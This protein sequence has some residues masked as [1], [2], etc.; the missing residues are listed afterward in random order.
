MEKPEA[1]FH[2]VGKV[3][4]KD[5]KHHRHF[6]PAFTE[7]LSNGQGCFNVREIRTG[8]YR[9]GRGVVQIHHLVNLALRG[10]GN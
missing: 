3:A 5:A 4:V 1:L 9:D 10:V 8:Q 7:R 2:H 6:I